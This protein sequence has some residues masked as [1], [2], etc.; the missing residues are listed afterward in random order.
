MALGNLT[1]LI[2]LALYF[3]QLTGTIP[4][5]LGNLVQTA[6]LFLDGNQLTGTNHSINFAKVVNLTR[7]D[8]NNTPLKLAPFRPFVFHFRSKHY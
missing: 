2:S 3:N 4:S 6:T 5:I 1:R 7:M 8:S